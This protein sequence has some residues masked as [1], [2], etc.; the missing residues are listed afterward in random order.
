MNSCAAISGQGKQ[1]TKAAEADKQVLCL[2][3]P[4][5]YTERNCVTNFTC[6]RRAERVIHLPKGEKHFCMK[7]PREQFYMHA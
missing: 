2:Q 7:I 1:Q 3:V 5:G 6:C 4:N